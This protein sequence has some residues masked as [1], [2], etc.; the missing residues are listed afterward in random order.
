MVFCLFKFQ[1]E[2]YEIRLELFSQPKMTILIILIIILSDL[3][4]LK[5]ELFLVNRAE[6]KKKTENLT[7]TF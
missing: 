3:Q 1:W 6:R 7:R 5:V 2:F 4:N